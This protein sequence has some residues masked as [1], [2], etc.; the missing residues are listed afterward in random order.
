MS[1]PITA[2]GPLKVETNPILM[3]SAATAGCAS[4]RTV[5]PA[6]QNAVLMKS[7]LSYLFGDVFFANS[8]ANG[9]HDLRL[10][11]KPQAGAATMMHHNSHLRRM[12]RI[13]I[14]VLARVA[15]T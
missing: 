11:S 13:I 2:V 10:P 8:K 12:A 5:A 9:K 14:Q 6:S 1:L 4:A 3:E 7:P 15:A